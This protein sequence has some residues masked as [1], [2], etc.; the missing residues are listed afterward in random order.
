MPINCN[1][2]DDLVDIFVNDW[3]HSLIQLITMA[4]R[5]IDGGQINWANRLNLKVLKRD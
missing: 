1:N 4:C 2:S 5:G 3:L